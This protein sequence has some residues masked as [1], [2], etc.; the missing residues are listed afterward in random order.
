MRRGYL[1][2]WPR[3]E[4]SSCRT[5]SG[6]S[7]P[8]DP[9]AGARAVA[10]PLIV[11]G[12]VIAAEA[13]GATITDVDGNTFLDFV[14]GIGVLNV[15]HNHPRVVDAV[16]RQLED[17]SHACF[18]VVSYRP[19][20]ELAARLNA[21]VGE[22]YKSAF[23]TS[24]AEAVENAVKI[25]RGYTRIGRPSSLFAAPFTAARCSVSR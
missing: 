13:R 25:A 21:L 24:G 5:D 4:P 2:A 8:R 12:P 10:R 19:Y 18:Q 20:I 15:G 6:P 7:R 3:R 16:R 22:G 17:V 11:H 1:S 9:R 23:F 14:G